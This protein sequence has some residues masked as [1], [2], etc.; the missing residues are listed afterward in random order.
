[1]SAGRIEQIGPPNELY[2]HPVNAFVASFLG[3]S[4]LLRG[5]VTARRGPSAQLSIPDLQ[6]NLWG[7]ADRLAPGDEAVALLRPEAIRL[8]ANGSNSLP[9]RVAETV[10]LGELIAIR[11]ALRTGQELWCRCLSAEPWPA[12][13]TEVRLGWRE[14]DVRIL[15]MS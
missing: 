6:I 9:A 12:D 10:Y 5:R 15:P 3:E 11:L 14:E 4:N 1:M 8:A 7:A 2:R 13:G